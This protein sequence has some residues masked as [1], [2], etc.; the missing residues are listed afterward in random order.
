MSRSTAKASRRGPAD[1]DHGAK[2]GMKALSASTALH[3][4][5]SDMERWDRVLRPVSMEK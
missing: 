5:A 1:N 2:P 3:V 4:V